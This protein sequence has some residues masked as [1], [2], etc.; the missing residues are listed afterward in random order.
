MKTFNEL[1]L[2]NVNE[3][4]EK[5]GKFTY[6]SWTWAVDTLLQNDPSATWTFGDPVYFNESVMVFCTVTA[7]G[8]S[9]TCQMPVLNHQNKAIPNP[10]AMDVNTAM[11]RCLVKTI[12]LFGIGLYIY[13]GEDLPD[14]E[15][16]DLSKEA[17]E[18]CEAISGATDLED[19][20][21]IFT[22]AWNEIKAD[23]AAVEMIG[24]AKDDRKAKLS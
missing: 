10:N 23:K 18:W 2:I 19:L 14:E 8:K 20:K 7:M 17:L 15:T 24:R 22:K 13:A 4:T 9:M 11:M 21:D 3:H 6:L 5:K 12:S 1:R 16:P